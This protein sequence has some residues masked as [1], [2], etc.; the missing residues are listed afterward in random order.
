VRQYIQAK[1]LHMAQDEIL[2]LI[3]KDTIERIKQS[4]PT[5]EFRVYCIGHEG[6]ANPQI[7]SYGQKIAMVLNYVKDM[8]VKIADRLQ[9]GTP[10]FHQHAGANTSDGREQ[11]GEV[12]GKAVRNIQNK[13]SALAAVYLYPQYRKMQLDIASI[14]SINVFVPKSDSAAEVIDV[15]EVTGI[16]LASSA[17]EKPAFAGATLLGAIQ[18]LRGAETMDKMTK[19]QI[20]EAI[21][22]S[23]FSITD[24]FSATDIIDSEPSQEAK[25]KERGFAKRKEE[26]FNAE[27]EKVID[28]QKKL[29]DTTGKVKTLT[30]KVN[31]T[32]AKTHIE[33]SLAGRKLDPKEREFIIKSAQKFTSEK[34][35]DELKQDVERFVDGQVKEF[36][37]IA[38]DMGY[39]LKRPAAAP[40]N[41]TP[42]AKA[43]REAAGSAAAAPATDGAA[44]G[45]DLSDPAK[46]DFIPA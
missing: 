5:P 4:D 15:R 24:I 23:G 38:K 42:E 35:G 13:I 22:E 11:I 46:N 31:T 45:G 16:A 34:E 25:K 18:A 26:E 17:T 12:V 43:A 6:D 32:A 36:E 10:I 9:F 20:K 44:A 1:I 3:P 37:G 39:E 40:A 29:D 21:R 41:E 19:E 30:Q 33:A 28:L 2:G 8:V 7:L 14:E 27:H